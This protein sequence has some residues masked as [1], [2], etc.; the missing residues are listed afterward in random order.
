[1]ISLD[2]LFH[3]LEAILAI[4]PISKRIERVFDTARQLAQPNSWA[5]LFE[6]SKFLFMISGGI[7]I[8]TLK[9]YIAKIIDSCDGR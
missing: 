7:F 8:V 1:M 2:I 5:E 3:I 4:D 9:T 6:I